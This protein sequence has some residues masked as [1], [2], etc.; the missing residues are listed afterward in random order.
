[1]KV[2]TSSETACMRNSGHGYSFSFEALYCERLKNSDL[3]HTWPGVKFTVVLP[4]FGRR[5]SLMSGTQ[6]NTERL[7]MKP[8]I[9][10]GVHWRVAKSCTASGLMN[11]WERL[12]RSWIVGITKAAVAI[13]KAAVAPSRSHRSQGL[14]NFLN[15]ERYRRWQHV[16][17]H[18]PKSSTNDFC[19]KF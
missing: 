14:K 18:V 13:T 10:L 6:R 7:W 2:G 3:I 4:C 15:S 1:M 17:I 8:I 11:P 5:G 16:L 9:L 12:F 19:T